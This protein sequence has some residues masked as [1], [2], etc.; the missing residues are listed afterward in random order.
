MKFAKHDTDKDGII[1]WKEYKDMTYGPL[2]DQNLED[3]EQVSFSM[4]Y[5]KIKLKSDKKK[6]KHSYVYTG[7]RSFIQAN[8]G[9]R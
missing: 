2:D 9:E 3:D 8:D 4:H 1:T 6:L 7:W 5:L